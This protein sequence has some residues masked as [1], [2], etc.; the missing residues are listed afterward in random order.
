MGVASRAGLVFVAIL[1]FCSV[2]IISTTVTLASFAEGDAECVPAFDPCGCNKVTGPDGCIGGLNKLFCPCKDV[3]GGG[4]TP[5]IC[6]GNFNCKATAT[7]KGEATMDPSKLLEALKGLM[8]KLKGKGGGGG[9]SPDNKPPEQ[10]T[11]DQYPNCVYNEA[12][13]TYSPI[14]CKNPDGTVNFGTFATDG[15]SLTSGQGS[16]LAASLLDALDGGDEGEF[17]Y[18]E[19]FDSLSEEEKETIGDALINTIT[20]EDASNEEEEEVPATTTQPVVPQGTIERLRSSL[21]GD[22]SVGEAGATFF[23]RSRD[24]ESNTEVAGFYGGGASGI[25]ASQSL[26]GRMCATRPWSGGFFSKIIP[27]GFF[28]GLCTRAGYIVGAAPVQT[29]G[30]PKRP[31]AKT[32]PPA[33][34]PKKTVTPAAAEVDIWA[35]PASVRLGTR[36]YIFWTSENVASCKATGPSFEQNSVSGGASTVP[37]VDTSTYKIVCLTAASTTVEDSVTVRLAL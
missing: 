5:G 25:G 16:S 22:I 35:E 10:K 21:F 14:P 6:V 33:S 4:K 24:A 17:D 26:V 29:G 7:N 3:S 18:G 20:G 2:F 28:D 19:Y 23:V 1:I 8:E 30:A 34:V 31:P 36:T 27:E 37:L 12:T 32:S 13:K 11:P 9:G 15:L